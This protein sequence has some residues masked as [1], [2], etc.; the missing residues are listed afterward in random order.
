M[1]TDDDLLASIEPVATQAPGDTDDTLGFARGLAY[2]LACV[3][4]FWAV[5]IASVWLAL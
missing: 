4:P 2:G 1:D 3:V 5:V